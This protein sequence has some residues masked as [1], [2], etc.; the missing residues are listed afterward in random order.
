MFVVKTVEKEV[1]HCSECPFY[2]EGHDMSM[3]FSCCE[4]NG[5]GYD[6]I[7]NDLGWKHPA[8]QNI[9]KSCKYKEKSI[10]RKVCGESEDEAL[11]LERVQDAMLDSKEF[12]KFL[13]HPKNFDDIQSA[14]YSRDIMLLEEI[15]KRFEKHCRNT[16]DEEIEKDF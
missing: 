10:D 5:E 3:T 15:R 6:A 1:S 14:L 16:V 8:S 11:K 4:L 9:S 12:D 13:N 7:L 2:Y